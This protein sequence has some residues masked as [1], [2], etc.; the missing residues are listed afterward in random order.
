MTMK[1]ICRMH[2]PVRLSW[3]QALLKDAGIECAVLDSHTGSLFGGVGF[4][5]PRLVVDEDDYDA[6]M[7]IL[8]DS[9][10]EI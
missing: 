4:L 6:A 5:G 1:E 3:M 7:R 8:R 9:G 2:D 10:E